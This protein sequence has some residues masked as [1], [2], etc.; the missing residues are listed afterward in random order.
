M[1]KPIKIYVVL[2]EYGEQIAFRRYENASRYM[3]QALE[4][5]YVS[6]DERNQFNL[7]EMWLC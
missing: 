7:S 2:P 1:A 4:E 3:E 5:D 6:E